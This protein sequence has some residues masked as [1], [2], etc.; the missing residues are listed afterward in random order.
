M[1]VA[2]HRR[3]NPALAASD[4]VSTGAVSA[5]ISNHPLKKVL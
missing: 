4:A 3:Q 5:F 1:I 2:N